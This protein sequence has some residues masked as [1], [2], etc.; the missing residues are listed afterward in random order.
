MNG[1]R[2]RL[3]RVV[4]ILNSNNVEYLI[5]GGY[6]LG[7]HGA[8]QRFHEAWQ[9]NPNIPVHIDRSISE[10][11][12]DSNRHSCIS[13]CNQHLKRAGNLPGNDDFLR[14]SFKFDLEKV[15]A[16][17]LKNTPVAEDEIFAFEQCFN[18]HRYWVGNDS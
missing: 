14:F 8:P 18:Q 13:I 16:P 10:I 4:E 9:C 1:V 5:V 2:G 6:A 17:H 11:L 15:H 3:Q 7:H 12:T